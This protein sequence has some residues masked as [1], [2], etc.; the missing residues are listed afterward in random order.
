MNSYNELI[1]KSGVEL[2]DSERLAVSGG[3]VTAVAMAA[4]VLAKVVTAGNGM[5]F[6]NDGCGV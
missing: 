5:C 3:S 1:S 4:F 2:L 6:A